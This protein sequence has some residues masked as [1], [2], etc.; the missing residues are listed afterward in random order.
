M[1]RITIRLPDTLIDTINATAQAEG[2]SVSNM[3]RLHLGKTLG[4]PT[5]PKLPIKNNPKLALQ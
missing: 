5:A 3:L 2:R 1:K 4:V